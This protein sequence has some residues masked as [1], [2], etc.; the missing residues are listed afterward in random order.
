AAKLAAAE[1]AS[2]GCGA[3]T[4]GSRTSGCAAQS[5]RSPGS[6]PGLVGGI[7]GTVG[8]APSG[9]TV[10]VQARVAPVIP[11]LRPCHAKLRQTCTPGAVSDGTVTPMCAG[12]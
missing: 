1:A 9:S 4:F 6:P 5:G 11:L 12:A 8:L 3:V 10:I 7:A 2:F